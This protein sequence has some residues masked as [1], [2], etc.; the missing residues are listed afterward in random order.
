MSQPHAALASIPNVHVRRWVEECVALCQPEKLYV[1]NGS[2]Q[3]KDALLEEGCKTGVFVKLNQQKRP[4]CYFHRSNPNDVA[5][6]EHLTFICGPT[7]DI[8]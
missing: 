7:E 5:R 8:A 3:E 2:K 6:V 1:C 4:G